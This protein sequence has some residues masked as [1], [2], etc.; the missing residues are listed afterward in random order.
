M[1]KMREKRWFWPAQTRDV[2]FGFQIYYTLAEKYY[3]ATCNTMVTML[4][5][6]LVTLDT[7]DVYFDGGGGGGGGGGGKRKKERKSF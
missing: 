2:H 7:F 5:R 3:K 4:T 1:T 6:P